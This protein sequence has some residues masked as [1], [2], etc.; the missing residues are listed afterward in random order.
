MYQA[1]FILGQNESTNSQSNAY[2][3]QYKVNILF[4]IKLFSIYIYLP[5]EN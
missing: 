5:F 1:V 4:A 2:T 3:H